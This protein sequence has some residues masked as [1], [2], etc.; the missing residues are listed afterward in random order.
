MANASVSSRGFIALMSA[1]VIAAVLLIVVVG[2]GLLNFFT[3]SNILDSELK[4]RSAALVDACADTVASR[5]LADNTYAGTETISVGSDGC[6]IGS[7]VTS[8]TNRTFQIEASYQTAY[9]H[10]LVTFDT[11]TG[12]L[13]SWQEVASF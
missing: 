10:A 4:A 1:V 5:L 7:S 6:R 2:A 12:S 8:G 9:T 3:R 13:V 11:G